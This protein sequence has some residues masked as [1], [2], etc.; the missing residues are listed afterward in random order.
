MSSRGSDVVETMRVGDRS[1]W[2]TVD[3]GG[4]VSAT[5]TSGRHEAIRGEL[6]STEVIDSQRGGETGYSVKM[7]QI[8]I[9]IIVSG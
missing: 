7:M 4:G 8:H 6:A 9:R 1:I 2:N 5:A 3:Q